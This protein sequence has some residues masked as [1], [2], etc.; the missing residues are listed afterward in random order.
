MLGTFYWDY[1]RSREIDYFEIIDPR[2]SLVLVLVLESRVVDVDGFYFTGV[3]KGF[4]IVACKNYRYVVLV[5]K[6]GRSMLT[7]CNL[8][9]NTFSYTAFFT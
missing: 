9:S 3:E 4:L 7:P 5:V 2:S 8:K 1:S 6:F